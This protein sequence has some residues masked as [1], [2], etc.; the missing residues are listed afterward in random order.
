MSA[1][2]QVTVKQASLT[3]SPTTVLAGKSSGSPTLPLA[4]DLLLVCLQDPFDGVGDSS[5]IVHTTVPAADGDPGHQ[6]R[7]EAVMEMHPPRFFEGW[8]TRGCFTLDLSASATVSPAAGTWGGSASTASGSGNCRVI[9]MRDSNNKL[10]FSLESGAWHAAEKP[11]PLPDEQRFL[12]ASIAFEANGASGLGAGAVAV[13]SNKNWS[14]LIAGSSATTKGLA[15]DGKW[16]Q[17]L[18][19]SDGDSAVTGAWAFM[20]MTKDAYEVLC[21]NQG[22]TPYILDDI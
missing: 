13:V 19:A 6:W 1:K 22:W 17:N 3:T 7:L 5:A 14:H 2:K 8:A 4:P 18:A 20:V 9:V 12:N 10:H 16:R 15:F 21:N 11:M